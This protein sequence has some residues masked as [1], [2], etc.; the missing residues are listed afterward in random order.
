MLEMSIIQKIAIWALPVLFAITGHEFAHGYV[1]SKFGDQSARLSG[2]L[3][4]NPIKHI[5]LVG[6]ILVPIMLLIMSNF[7]FGWAKPVPVDSRNMRNPRRDMAIVSAAGPLSNLLMALF[8]AGVAKLGLILSPME[9]WF[10]VPLVYMGEAGILINV[11]LAVLN[12]LPIPPLDGARFLYNVLPGRL[13]WHFHRLEPYGF[14]ILILLMLSG[15]LSDFMSPIVQWVM[16]LITD[17][18]AL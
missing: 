7:I 16:H 6:T 13:A 2:R 11:V 8:W 3:T 10:S 15:F 18:F 17:L 9:N 1:A 14:F 5:D 12:L 4:L